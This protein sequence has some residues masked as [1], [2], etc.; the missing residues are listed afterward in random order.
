MADGNIPF[1]YEKSPIPAYNRPKTD[2]KWSNDDAQRVELYLDN[3][4]L[5]MRNKV[6][7]GGGGL[8]NTKIVW[9]YPVSMTRAR[10]T[11]FSDIWKKLYKKYFGEPTDDKLVIMSESVAP[12]YY[13]KRDLGAKSNVVTID[14][15][16]GT[17]DVYVVEENKP[18][19][20]SSFRFAANS[21]FGD[22][23][24]FPP[25]SNGFV[26]TFKSD[27]QGALQANKQ[28]ELINAFKS[29]EDTDNSTDIIAFFFSLASNKA[30]RGRNVPV[31]FL[32]ML[33]KNDKLKY[34][35]VVFYGAILYYVAKMMK[36]KGLALPQ[37]LAFSGNGSKTLKVLSTDKA[38]LAKF[39]QLIFEKVFS[40]KY[41]G[42]SLEV[43]YEDEPKL[44][45]CKGGISCKENLT[46]DKIEE[47]KSSLLGTDDVKFTNDYH[48]DM[49]KSEDINAVANKVSEF[50]DFLFAINDENKN[51][52]V[53]SLATDASVIRNVKEIC[54]E[55]LV[56][57][58]KQGLEKKLDEIK[59]WGLGNDSEI[60]ETLFF[61]PI[62]A[63]LSNLA[64]KIN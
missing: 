40:Q 4:F 42:S 16:G 36:A 38:T 15:G 28:N 48:Y 1:R 20:L 45:T 17:T 49:I 62:V 64:R 19:M 23:Y 29:I 35:F 8:E 59:S 43:I 18:V 26:N 25:R 63:M 41:T 37:T 21:V 54:K 14:I 53:D 30:F 10:C 56:E 33:T 47:L 60:E 2:L 57:Y 6:V 39:A 51:F 3:L 31:D 34:T 55:D 5:L 46:Y 11:R 13:Y 24:N 7:L 61:Y 50:I 27:I 52:F 44:A 32:E 22:G 58:T 9:F 12:Y